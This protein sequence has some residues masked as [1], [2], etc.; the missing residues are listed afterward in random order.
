MAGAR[1]PGAGRRWQGPG[2]PPATI[3]TVGGLTLLGLGGSD[4]V[5][6]PRSRPRPRRGRSTPAGRRRAAREAARQSARSSPRDAEAARDSSRG[7]SSRSSAEIERP[8]SLWSSIVYVLLGLAGRSTPI[9]STA[10]RSVGV[11]S[12]TRERPRRLGLPTDHASRSTSERTARADQEPLP[13]P[14]ARDLTLSASRP[15]V[16]CSLDQRPSGHLVRLGDPEQLQRGRRD[17]GEDAARRRSSIPSTVAISGTGFV[18]C[19]VLGEP[20][21]LSM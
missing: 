15:S 13:P 9:T 1:G 21:G 10:L 3:C 7:S 12:S 11:T 6:R 16:Y 2:R 19:A 14:T 4:R 17:V 5:R 20:S 8:R 18:V